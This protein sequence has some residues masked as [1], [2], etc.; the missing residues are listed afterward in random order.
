MDSYEYGELLKTLQNKC[1]NI[2]K[3]LN[4]DSL[5]KRLDEINALESHQE[6][7]NDAKKA[8]EITKEKRKCE[9]ILSTY[10]EM[11]AELTQWQ[12]SAALRDHFMPSNS[13]PPG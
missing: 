1:E 10:T 5:Q 9:R 12:A 11:K 3:I 7:W 8:G 2:A 4:P 6:F 13:V